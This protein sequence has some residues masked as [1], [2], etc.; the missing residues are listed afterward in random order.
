MSGP[1]VPHPQPA[2]NSNSIGQFQIGVSPLGTIPPFDFWVTVLSQYGNSERLTDLIDLYNQAHDQTANFD[3]FYD[4]VWNIQTAKGHGLDVWGRILGVP[5]TLQLP[6]NV[7]YFGFEEAGTSW[8][9]FG[10]S[11]F[12]TGGGITSNYDLSD[13]DYRVVLLAKAA[14]NICDGSIVAINAILMT[15]FQGLGRCYVTDG[16]DMT[17]TYTFEFPLTQVQVGIVETAGVLP[18]PAGVAATVVQTF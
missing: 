8:T 4:F 11:P 3:N 18:K 2:F 7:G 13:E 1:P 17:M 10:Q 9:G 5:R 12:Y 6:G 15:L 14:S 16:Q